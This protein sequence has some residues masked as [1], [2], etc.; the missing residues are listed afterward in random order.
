MR[1]ETESKYYCIEPERLINWCE[2]KGLKKINYLV[3][4]DEYFTDLDSLF[5]RNRT[6]LRLRDTNHTDLE[7]TFKGK[8]LELLGQYS[9]IENNIKAHYSEYDK[10]VALF[11]SLGF[12]SYVNV[13][14]ERIIYNY[15]HSQYE[16]NIMID[17][18]FGIGGFVEFEVITDN[19]I[20]EKDQLIKELDRF[21]QLFK[22]FNLIEATEPYRDLV[23][24][25]IYKSN[26]L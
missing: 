5:I 11:S 8:S 13:N 16:C 17:K 20:Y 14:K 6:C 23:A 25:N 22:E 19:K 18:L 26:I 12:Y 1:V 10:Y 3:E 7:I 9:K 15:P 21:V 2:I 4:N 24:K